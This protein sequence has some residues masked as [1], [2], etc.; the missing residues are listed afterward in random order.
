MINDTFP[1]KACLRVVL[2][3]LLLGCFILAAFLI[4]KTMQSTLGVQWRL[5][6]LGL[7]A[8]LACQAAGVFLSRRT[9]LSLGL[10]FVGLVLVIIIGLPFGAWM[11]L[12]LALWSILFVES[13]L[14][15]APPLS[16]VCQAVCLS[17][18][19]FFQGRLS[20][21]GQPVLGPEVVD[22]IAGA[23]FLAVL[24]FVLHVLRLLFAAITRQ[25]QRLERLDEAVG[26]LT[27]A[28]LGFQ[29]L[30]AAA[31]ERSAEDERKR[32][33]R[34][35][36]DAIGYALTNLIMTTEACMRLASGEA[37]ALRQLLV[38]AREEAQVGLNETRKALR[39]LRGWSPPKTQGLLAV[40]QLVKL[41]SEATGVAVK[42]EYCNADMSFG[43][44]KDA[45]I[46]RM[47]QEGMTNAFRHGR[48]SLIKVKFW[49][50]QA[51]VSVILW[52][53][54]VAGDSFKEGLGLQGMRERIERIG[55]TL[56]VDRTLDGFELSTWLPLGSDIE[57]RAGSYGQDFP[58]LG[59]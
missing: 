59:G 2:L 22:L 6:S 52:D 58:A 13:T 21:W 19:M 20:A 12:K 4:L 35:I 7:L 53:N 40:Q 56:R 46:Y 37:P 26:R 28:N 5:D 29:N 31:Q 23:L 54:G 43:D 38:R 18:I 1:I 8:L 36:H 45:V 15:F 25:Q 30:A 47:I 55:G 33:T 3:I 10:M 32:I 24:A 57:E 34:E 42:T 17:V 9:P 49:Q 27:S 14:A 11:A 41:F 48:A 44:E 50:E 39:V 51:G 16:F